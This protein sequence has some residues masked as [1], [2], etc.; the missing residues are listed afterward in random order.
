MA[1]NNSVR[2]TLKVRNDTAAHWTSANPTLAAGE[3]GLE[4]DTFLFKIGDGT[5]PWNSLRYLN[6]FDNS[7]FTIGSDGEISIDQTYAETLITTSGGTIDG[8]LSLLDAPVND[9]DATNKLYVDTQVANAGHLK[10]EIV[11][12]LPAAVDADPD[13]IYMVKDNSAA[14]ADKYKEYMK[15]GNAIEQIGDTSVDLNGLVTGAHT[16]GNLIMVDN[17]GALVDAGIIAADIGKLE[18]GTTSVLGGVKS[19]IADDFV[20]ITTA[21]DSVGAGFMTL[22]NVSTTKLYVPSGDTL[23]L[24]GGNSSGG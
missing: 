15:I 10:R 14:G 11:V 1:E 4:N 16:A 20:R 6:K 21:S 19:S 7:Y 13:T 24:D 18:P 5:T 23:I 2:V 17:S 12:N 9:T 22:N 8:T 3:W